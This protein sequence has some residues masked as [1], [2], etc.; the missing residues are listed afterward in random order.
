MTFVLEEDEALK[1][2]L[3]G[4]T[5]SDSSNP[6][7][8]V[9]VWYG[10]PDLELAKRTYPYISIE[11]VDINEANERVMVGKP[12]LQYLPDGYE[13]PA[14]NVN[15]ILSASWFPTP[16]NLDY[17]VTVWSRHPRHD[18]ELLAKLL[19]GP[20]PIRFGGLDLPRSYREV[21]LDMLEGPRVSDTTDENGKRLFRKV[22]TVRVATELFPVGSL[23]TLEMVERVEFILGVAREGFEVIEASIP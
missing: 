4:L 5:V 9:Q 13:V 14:D 12:F 11:L 10:Q 8:E 22:F 20:L 23:P 3:S 7:R 6:A 21:R 2:K 18:R 17:Q 19:A 15:S 16:Y 1:L